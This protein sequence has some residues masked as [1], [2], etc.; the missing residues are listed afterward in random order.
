M[1]LIREYF[2][3]I[4]EDA[5]IVLEE[6]AGLLREWNK[7]INLVSRR[8]ID[9]LEVRHLSHCLAIT[10]HLKLMDGARI[11]DVGTGGGFPGMIMAICYPQAR[12][13][14]I[15]SI[16][17]KI[18]SVVDMAER[19][20]LENIEARQCRAES[21]EQRFDFIT[22]R[23][24][25]NLPEFFGWIQN[26]LREGQRHSIPN[27]VLYWKGGEIK[28]ELDRLGIG[29]RRTIQ[30]EKELTDPFFKQKYLLHFDARDIPLVRRA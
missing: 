22:G 6:W 2:P 7:K 14:L 1:D 19:L 20:R 29:P 3:N 27:G 30:L 5:W 16:G 21:V 28:S 24:V 18:Q 25:K 11:M 9:H 23:A 13:T 15:D 17:K 12:F 26:N 4:N 8:E 10:N